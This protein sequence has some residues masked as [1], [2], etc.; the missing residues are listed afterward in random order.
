MRFEV[1]RLKRP[2]CELPPARL[3]WQTATHVRIPHHDSAALSFI[4]QLTPAQEGKF[5]FAF[6]ARQW[7]EWLE[8]GAPARKPNFIFVRHD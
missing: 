6:Q 5:V 2:I 3:L 1:N 8:P 4:A 7:W